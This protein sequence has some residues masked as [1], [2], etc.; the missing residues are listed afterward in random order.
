V[1]VPALALTL[2]VHPLLADQELT[3]SHSTQVTYWEGA[4]EVS[5]QLHGAP[6]AGQGY[7]ELTGYAKPM[8]QR[9]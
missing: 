9:L 3:T 5:G 4:V 1:T 6:V 2:D 8:K 7:V